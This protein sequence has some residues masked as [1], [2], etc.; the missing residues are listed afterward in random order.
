MIFNRLMCLTFL[1][2][3]CVSPVV[4]ASS[5]DSC[6]PHWSL[7]RATLDGCSS[8]PFLS[9][10][11][12]TRVNLQLLLADSGQLKLQETPIS[13]YDRDLGYGSVPFRREHLQE[14]QEAKAP[15]PVAAASSTATVTQSPLAGL[16]EK[17]GVAAPTG[18]PAGA[19]FFDGE[20]SRCVSN[21]N[22]SAGDFLNELVSS[23]ELPDSERQALARSRLALLSACSWDE[24]Q[25]AEILPGNI[26]TPLGKLF[27]RYLS[28]AVDFYNGNFSAAEQ[29]FQA[30]SDSEQPWL[31]EVG[32][33]LLARTPLNAAQQNAFDE[34]GYP[35]LD[36]VD[37][38]AMKK[39]EAGF[40]DYLRAYPDG[41][42]SSSAKGLLRRVYWLMGNQRQLANEFAG[43]FELKSDDQRTVPVIDLVQEVDNKLL[44][45]VS[46][47][48][49]QTP[50]LLAII[51]LMKFRH[52][53]PSDAGKPLTLEDLKAQH[54]VFAEHHEALYVYLLGAFQL[55]VENDPAKTLQTL[56]E[57]LPDNGLDYVDFSRQTLRGF[58][59]EMQKDW[60][61][62]EKLW[63]K[64]LPVAKQPYQR[65][66]L[67][68]ALA[69]NYERSNRLAQV[70]ASDSPIQ[71]PRVRDNLLRHVA[72]AELLRQ[73]VKQGISAEER[74]TALFILLYKD[75][76]RSR[77]QDFGTDMALLADKPSDQLL[78]SSTVYSYGG[79]S[80]NLFHWKGDKAESGY[81][82]PS[83]AESIA[84]LQADS[85]DPVG[86]NCLGEFFLRNRLDSMPL[87]TQPEADELGG[88]ASAFKGEVFSRLDGY[89]QVMGHSKASNA[90]KAY[91]LYRAIN[92]FAPAGYNTC[93]SQD[94][95]QSL[96][97]QWFRELKSKYGNT[98]WAKDLK[99][100]W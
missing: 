95:A 1:A 90:D 96:R 47:T 41:Q 57:S 50:T 98:S 56:P 17:L 24:S 66:Q 76:S 93:G 18:D 79:Q 6:E 64:M 82:C 16:A 72:S 73:Q 34:M 83:I 26:E 9:P 42:Y 4:H 88:S 10:G 75:L 37:Q 2:A 77:Y 22:G 44:A 87:D 84:T 54:P 35:A 15:E 70:F 39:A 81:A 53:E 100:Y 25:Q 91:A 21:S 67:E 12:D 19:V 71:S 58:A 20:G 13:D 92:C 14:A 99:Y 46:P 62:A 49:V 23:G 30:L 45:T 11:N 55:Y 29:G 48:D 43:Q 52:R 27:A 69:L 74:D 38:P 31:K 94:I 65:A 97:K 61:G 28:A 68:L 33:Y 63:L 32:H 59:L 60:A 36:K 5:D 3:G 8:V 85:E 86:L 89:R 7:K 51:D 40:L 78:T 80:L